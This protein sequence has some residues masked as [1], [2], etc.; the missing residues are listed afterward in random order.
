M[1]T[2]SCVQYIILTLEVLIIL[3]NV[4]DS[5]FLSLCLLTLLVTEHLLEL[6]FPWNKTQDRCGGRDLGVRQWKHSV[7]WTLGWEKRGVCLPLHLA[8]WLIGS[9][10]DCEGLY[11]I[12][13]DIVWFMLVDQK[14]VLWIALQVVALILHRRKSIFGNFECLVSFCSSFWALHDYEIYNPM[15]LL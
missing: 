7:T 6:L 3:I 14:N 13:F 11:L 9:L 1:Q 4:F 8:Y 10:V 15:E 2:T 12:V 5:W